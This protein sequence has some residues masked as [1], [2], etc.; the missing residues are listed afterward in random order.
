MKRQKGWA[1]FLVFGIILL[2]WAATAQGV[3]WPQSFGVFTDLGTLGPYPD[4]TYT[5]SEARGVNDLGQVVGMSTSPNTTTQQYR[6]FLWTPGQQ[7]I[8]LGVPTD[9]QEP[10]LVYWGAP[11]YGINNAGQIIVDCWVSGSHR[12]WVY[13]GGA[14]TKLKRN[15]EE[16]W[17]NSMAWGINHNGQIAGATEFKLTDGSVEW[18]ACVWDSMTA[19]PRPLGTLGKSGSNARGINN[20]GWVVGDARL[21]DDSIHAF[22]WTP[23]GGMQDLGVLIENGA[24]WATGINDSGWIAGYASKSF[25]FGTAVRWSPAKVIENLG[26]VIVGSPQSAAA[27]AINNAGQIT[28]TDWSLGAYGSGRGFLYSGGIMWDIGSPSGSPND[29]NSAFAINNRGQIVGVAGFPD[30]WRAF[31]WTPASKGLAHINLLL[32]D[33]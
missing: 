15:I 9:T 33:Q 3:P 22:L 16:G 13:Q 5:Y 11:A 1:A 32:L 27:Y 23:G 25:S 28:G 30:G 31:L 6:G 7:M 19:A 29:L 26:N 20:N 2:L 12:A 14:W 24:S 10:G 8:D 21:P 4:S 17:V 18:Q